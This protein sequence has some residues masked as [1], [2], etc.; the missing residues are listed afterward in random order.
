MRA[1]VWWHFVISVCSVEYVAKGW[2]LGGSVRG[3]LVVF[4]IALM[5]SS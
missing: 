1:V 2:I 4:A 3:L 5:Q